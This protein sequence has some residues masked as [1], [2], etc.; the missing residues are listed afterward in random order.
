[1]AAYKNI[2]DSR[3][4]FVSPFPCAV[5]GIF[6]YSGL[7]LLK[8]LTFV[9]LLTIRFLMIIY[10]VVPSAMEPRMIKTTIARTSP[11]WF[12]SANSAA[13]AAE[14]LAPEIDDEVTDTVLFV[15]DIDDVKLLMARVIE[16]TVVEAVV[17]E[18]ASEV[19][20]VVVV[21]VD[22]LSF[23]DAVDADVAV[24]VVVIRV[25]VDVVDGNSVLVAAVE[26]SDVAV[27]ELVEDVT[28]L[29]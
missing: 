24:V 27:K 5:N 29:P 14:L 22:E 9:S 2:M 8:P 11:A 6:E 20:A 28:S 23:V 25:V 19:S 13:A 15:V 21:T 4:A 12:H 7:V 26:V 17:E 16:E 10:N 1:M 18:I 3:N